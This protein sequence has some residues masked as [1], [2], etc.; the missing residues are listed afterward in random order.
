[1]IAHFSAAWAFQ[2]IPRREPAVCMKKKN[3]QPFG[4]GHYEKEK[5]FARKLTPEY[6]FCG[7]A[8]GN[9]LM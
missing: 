2:V 7:T 1:M 5:K 9:D 8:S 6:R 3:P 4:S